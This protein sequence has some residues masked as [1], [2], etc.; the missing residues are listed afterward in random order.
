[1]APANVVCWF[2]IPVTDMDRAT[3]FYNAVLKTEL[4]RND[5]GPNPMADFPTADQSGVSGHIYPGKPA[6]SGSGATIHLVSPDELEHAMARVTENG[7]QVVS[8]VIPIPVGK[9]FYALDPAGS[10]IGLFPYN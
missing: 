5:A 2:E 1:M 10:S 4:R 3:K 8:P 6:A 9:F 7:G